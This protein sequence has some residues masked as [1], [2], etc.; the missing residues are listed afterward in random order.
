MHPILIKIGP[1]TIYTYGFFFAL[2]ILSGLMLSLKLAKKE[3]IDR[4]KISDLIF[5]TILIALI[6]A[7][8]SLFFHEI[9]YYLKYPSEIKYLLTSGGT[10]YG[11][12]IFGLIFAFWYIKKHKLNLKAILDIAGPSIALGHF[13]GRLGCFSAGC[14]FGRP[15]GD[16][17][18]GVVFKNPFAGSHTGVPLNT[19]IY[20]TQLME[21]ILNLLNFIILF[22]AFK[23]KK[24]EG[25]IFVM[26][27]FNYSIIR[28][29]VEYFRGD[30][31]RGYIFGGV[32]H[33]FTSLS[34]PQFISIIG[35]IASF[36]LYFKFK[37]K[38]GKKYNN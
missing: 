23:K 16:S 34:V 24:F 26:Y 19:P 1:I 14:C 17:I 21:S 12:L 30:L 3:N 8:L 13:F 22:F 28:F 5:Y 33:T 9:K 7:K 25:Q 37:K 15:A 6:G 38:S 2:G 31:D 20:P 18:I 35:I 32:S 10:F 4:R 36:I 27:I 29:F 11:G